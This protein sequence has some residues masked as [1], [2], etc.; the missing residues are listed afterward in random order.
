[1]FER[2]TE[3]ARRVVVQAQDEARALG[4]GA[5]G[6]EH[7]LIAIASDPEARAGAALR[8]SGA[9]A[10]AL[11]TTLAGLEPPSRLDADALAAIGID[12]AAVRRRVEASFGPGAL[13]HRRPRP[14][15]R[16][17]FSPDA[18]K[19]LELS[20]RYAVSRH[21][22]DIQAEHL[23]L[24]VLRAMPADGAAAAALGRLRVPPQRIRERLDGETSA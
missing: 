7:L 1:M 15:G 22:H 9:D 21:D 18:K 20:L 10:G 19:G 24:G 14:E 11:R 17:P 12:L 4:H 6:C 13:E 23:L 16:I 5:I 8:D 3:P 2:F